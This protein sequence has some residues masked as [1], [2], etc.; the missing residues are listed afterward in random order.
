MSQPG[1]EGGNGSGSV[2]VAGAGVVVDIT[3]VV[4]EFGSPQLWSSGSMYSG[5][6][7]A[8]S[9]AGQLAKTLM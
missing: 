7:Q 6:L 4:V 5:Q 1:Q 8:S 3:T 9:I 2:V